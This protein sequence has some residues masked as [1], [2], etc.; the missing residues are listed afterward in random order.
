MPFRTSFRGSFT[1]TSI[2]LF[3]PQTKGVYGILNSFG[4]FIYIGMS[5]DN[6][7]R[8]LL[9]HLRTNSCV[10]ARRPAKFVVETTDYPYSREA[11]LIE[12]YDP[13]CNK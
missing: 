10:K 7:Q 11:I 2:S 12:E 8:R 6:V 3:A 5:S 13:V 1:D 9:D 4:N